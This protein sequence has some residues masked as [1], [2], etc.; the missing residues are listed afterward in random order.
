MEAPAATQGRTNTTAPVLKASQ[1]STVRE[2]RG[3]SDAAWPWDTV[4][5]SVLPWVQFS[6]WHKRCVSTAERACMSNP[7]S[8]G[9]SCAETSQGFEC[10]CAPGWT[11]P[12]CSISKSFCNFYLKQFFSLHRSFMNICSFCL[13]CR[14]V[15]DESL[16][17]WGDLPGP[18]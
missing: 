5:D 18:G 4:N 12:S 1:G 17:S 7:C 2:V 10:H 9:G 14:R 6:K 15:R 13:R 3:T 8:N 16:Q 11:G